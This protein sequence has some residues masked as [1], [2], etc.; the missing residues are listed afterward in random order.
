MT[1]SRRFAR[2]E[3]RSEPLL[4]RR[5]FLRRVLRH[6]AVA[7]AITGASLGIGIVGYHLAEGFSW[8]DSFLNA[9]MILTGM[10]PATPLTSVSGKVF[11]SCYALFSGLVFLAVASI[12]VAPIAHRVLHRLHLEEERA[13]AGEG[14]AAR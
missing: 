3:H 1:P 11:A 5:R 13:E 8:L 10:G 4:S 6:G 7:G 14:R 9:S 12:V 2:Y